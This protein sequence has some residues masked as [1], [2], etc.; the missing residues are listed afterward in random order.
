MELDNN[1]DRIFSEL[2]TNK[3][4]THT[5]LFRN[6]IIYH[7]HFL[8]HGKSNYLPLSN[9]VKAICFVYCCQQM[10]KLRRYSTTLHALLSVDVSPT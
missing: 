6:M 9:D 2:N 4:H 10:S 3:V 7:S 8:L 1:L 5:F